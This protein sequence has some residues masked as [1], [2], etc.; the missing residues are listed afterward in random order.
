MKSVENM[1]DSTETHFRHL[2]IIKCANVTCEVEG[3]HEVSGHS[4][5][6]LRFGKGTMQK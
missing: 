3:A 5:E 6:T 2:E 4:L 1:K